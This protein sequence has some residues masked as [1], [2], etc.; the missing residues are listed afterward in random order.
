MYIRAVLNHG[1]HPSRSLII[2]NADTING[3]EKQTA[4]EAVAIHR[5]TLSTKAMYTSSISARHVLTFEWQFSTCPNRYEISPFQNCRHTDCHLH[6][7]RSVPRQVSRNGGEIR[8]RVLLVFSANEQNANFEPAYIW[9]EPLSLLID[10]RT[11]TYSL[12]SVWTI[13][14]CRLN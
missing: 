7:L 9:T 4:T 13:V 12:C 14:T 1:L 2:L 11:Y 3:R 6:A 5:W 8:P 10:S